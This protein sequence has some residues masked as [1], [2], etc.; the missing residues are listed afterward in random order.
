MSGLSDELNEEIQGFGLKQT[1][2]RLKVM[3]LESKIKGRVRKI[4]N[5][6]KTFEKPKFNYENVVLLNL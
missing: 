5:I 3:E 1:R 6:N 4:K 2:D